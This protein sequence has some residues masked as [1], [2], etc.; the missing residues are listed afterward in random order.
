MVSWNEKCIVRFREFEYDDTDVEQAW[1]SDAEINDFK[2]ERK[3]IKNLVKRFA[4]LEVYERT[5][6]DLHS[7]RGLE[8]YISRTKAAQ[9][10]EQIVLGFHLVCS[11]QANQRLNPSKNADEVISLAYQ[12]V[13]KNCAK[14]ALAR[15]LLYMAWNN[16]TAGEQF[17]S[18]S[19]KENELTKKNSESILKVDNR[20]N[21]RM[22]SSPHSATVTTSSPPTSDESNISL[23]VS[24]LSFSKVLA[25]T[26][27]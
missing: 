5:M 2:E 26:R 1:Y 17:R 14:E 23:L 6:G 22:S 8:K 24:F 18:N 10:K 15:A 25:K 9:R 19:S 27:S 4:S 13:T 11:A 20:T 21:K 16:D 7:S 12:K 3:Q